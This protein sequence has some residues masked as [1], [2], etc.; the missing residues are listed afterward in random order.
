MGLMTLV[1][2]F[3]GRGKELCKRMRS[4]EGTTLSRADLQVLRDQLKILH[5]ETVTLL[6][7]RK[8]E[9]DRGT[10]APRN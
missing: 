5:R 4:Q 8:E 10:R 2:E 9:T 1:S 6:D 7:R 3:L